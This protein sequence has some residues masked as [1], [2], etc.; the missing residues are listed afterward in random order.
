[1]INRRSNTSTVTFKG[2][3][4]WDNACIPEYDKEIFWMAFKI[5]VVS[6]GLHSLFSIPDTS[7]K[8]HFLVEY[9]HLFS[10]ASVC[11]EYSTRMTRQAPLFE[12]DS[13]GVET[14]KKVARP[15]NL[16]QKGI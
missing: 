4:E 9:S 1:M 7:K 6:S 10:L 5:Q 11:N 3:L 12:R 15:Y 14:T 13:M 2:N 16:K 8:L